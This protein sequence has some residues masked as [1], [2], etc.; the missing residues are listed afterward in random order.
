MP[1]VA[2]HVMDAIVEALHQYV[3]AVIATDLAPSTK[4]TY[5][6]HAINFVRWLDD[7][8]DPASRRPM[9]SR[10]SQSDLEM[11]REISN[12]AQEAINRSRDRRNRYS[13]SNPR[14]T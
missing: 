11:F 8:F 2:P 6:T 12:R 4:R 9:P 7:D 14:T 1:K 3:D 10:L 5:F 13:N